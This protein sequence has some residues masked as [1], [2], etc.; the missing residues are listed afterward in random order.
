MKHIKI[1][2]KKERM[3][4]FSCKIEENTKKEVDKMSTRTVPRNIPYFQSCMIKLDAETKK[5]KRWI[6]EFTV[7]KDEVYSFEVYFF[8]YEKNQWR[9]IGF[10]KQKENKEWTVFF[11]TIYRGLEMHASEQVLRLLK[12]H[13][14]EKVRLLFVPG[15]ERLKNTQYPEPKELT[16]NE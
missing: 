6:V 14:K 4:F 13:S 7:E 2:I 1:I 12:K 11:D 16:I 3:L 15:D 5:G 10:K 8:K 9:T